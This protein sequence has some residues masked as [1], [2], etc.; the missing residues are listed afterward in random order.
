[1]SQPDCVWSR[2]SFLQ[3]FEIKLVYI[4]SNPFTCCI[5]IGVIVFMVVFWTWKAVVIRD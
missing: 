3:T 4:I 5:F 1:M 2:V